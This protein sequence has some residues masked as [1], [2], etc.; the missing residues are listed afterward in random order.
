MG[1]KRPPKAD[2]IYQ[3]KITLKEVKPPVW[4]RIQ[5]PARTKLPDL[6]LMIQAAMGWYNG[7]LHCFTIGGKA[8]GELNPDWDDPDMEDE[9]RVRLD[10]VAPGKG[11]RFTYL[12][13]FGDGWEHVIRVEA[14]LPPKPGTQYPRC[15]DGGRKC[16]PEDCGG[17]WGYEEFLVAIRDPKH[18]EHENMREWIGGSFDP[19][20][21]DVD[22]INANLK[23]YR[24]FDMWN[25]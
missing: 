4:R 17:P 21:F 6:H 5:V 20:R 19:E 2:L 13:D 18:E 16:P 1:T 25:G 12:Y 10:Q 15:L 7:H 9:M 23:Q 11:D 22:E 24:R 14:V 8:Y 3:L